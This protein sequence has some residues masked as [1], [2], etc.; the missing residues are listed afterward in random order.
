[1]NIDSVINEVTNRIVTFTNDEDVDIPANTWTPIARSSMA[2]NA[3]TSLLVHGV[4]K[5]YLDLDGLVKF[6]YHIMNKGYEA[7][8]HEIYMHEDVDT[9]T[10]FYVL[11][12]P[13]NDPTRLTVEV[14]TGNATGKIYKGDFHGAYTGSHIVVEGWDGIL[15]AEEEI[16]AILGN[17]GFVVTS[18]TDNVDFDWKD[19]EFV[20]ASDIISAVL[21]NG[22]F[23]VSGVTDQPN[24]YTQKDIY[25]IV[26]E[27]KTYRLVSE[28]DNYYFESEE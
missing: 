14:N 27:D 15:D 28:D 18:I 11:I 13:V 5:I 7:F 23:V 2:V 6:R 24:V 1:M 25:N 8:V 3:E 17:G 20:N 12:P 19:V 21:G 4:A 9:A 26:S 10:L 22:G 16:T